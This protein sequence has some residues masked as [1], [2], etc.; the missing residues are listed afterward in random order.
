MV[1]GAGDFGSV[2]IRDILTMRRAVVNVFV[3]SRFFLNIAFG[4]VIILLV[5]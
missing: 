3:M 4:F 1:V 2:G 5:G